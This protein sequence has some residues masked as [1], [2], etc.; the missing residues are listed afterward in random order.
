MSNRV[1]AKLKNRGR[2]ADSFCQI[3][4]DQVVYGVPSFDKCIEYD[5]ERKLEDDQ[6]F[7][8]DA[9]SNKDYC[10]EYL[11]NPLQP[12]YSSIER[13]DYK[14]IDYI[15]GT[16][17][18][19]NILWFLNVTPGR[20]IKNPLIQ[21]L[22]NEP[23]LI[24]NESDVLELAN[25]PSAYFDVRNDKLYFKNLSLITSLFKGIEVLF[26]EA[27]NDEVTEFL[28][29]AI[30]DM[31]EGYESDMIKTQNRKRLKAAKEKYESFS[32]EQKLLLDE[33]LHDYCPE[34]EKTDNGYKVKN[35]V[36]MTKLLNGINQRY[37]T[38]PVDKERRLANSVSV[39]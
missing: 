30:V 38:T 39:L 15:F 21:L 32:D 20:Y 31:G 8:I 14:R 36:E 34:L 11:K 13:N 2:S 3:F 10:P 27:T 22:N 9:F 18:N 28:E 16:I 29:S 5:D 25:E 12:L 19:E 37:Y 7:C 4:N 35:E 6:W 24:E 1:I 23:K 26:R 33:Y 17:D